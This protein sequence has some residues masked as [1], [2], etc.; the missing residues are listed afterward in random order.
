MGND[1]VWNLP[2]VVDHANGIQSRAMRNIHSGDYTPPCVHLSIEN[3]VIA[4]AGKASA[5]Q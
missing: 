4:S 2:G 3:H 5:S 1:K